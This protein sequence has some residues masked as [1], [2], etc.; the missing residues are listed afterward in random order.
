MCSIIFTVI[1]WRLSIARLK[2]SLD[3]IKYV[4]FMGLRNSS[5]TPELLALVAASIAFLIS[6]L[7][8]NAEDSLLLCISQFL[9]IKGL[10]ESKAPLLICV[11]CYVLV[12]I[13]SALIYYLLPNSILLSLSLVSMFLLSQYVS[14]LAPRYKS[15]YLSLF[16]SVMI[17]GMAN[18]G[19]G[20]RFQDSLVTL[21]VGSLVVCVWAFFQGGYTGEPSNYSMSFNTLVAATIMGIVVYLGR[22]FDPTLAL[23]WAIAALSMSVV[24]L[25]HSK[26][27]MFHR[28]IGAVAGSLAAFFVSQ[29]LLV[30]DVILLSIAYIASL[31]LFLDNYF[32][33]YLIRSFMVMLFILLIAFET[34]LTLYR[35]AVILLV[36]IATLIIRF[37]ADRLYIAARS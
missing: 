10:F 31:T 27:K 6:V 34:D 18:E 9:I 35:M 8:S 19:D 17:I 24:P 4:S 37:G 20:Q 21:A 15:L 23:W 29:Y 7:F 2:F 36:G 3:F 13:F 16:V 28:A 32:Q 5:E 25:E 33:A 14:S 1:R 11:G 30:S 22:L 12:V 26:V